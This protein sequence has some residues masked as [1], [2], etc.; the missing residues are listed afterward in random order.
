MLTSLAH[1]YQNAQAGPP[2]ESWGLINGI[3]KFFG[4]EPFDPKGATAYDAAMKT[5]VNLAINRTSDFATGA[6]A[7]GLEASMMATP[8]P[9]KDPDALYDIITKSIGYGD[10]AYDRSQQLI[11]T[12][13]KNAL[14]FI[15]DFAE[16][17]DPQTYINKAKEQI[18]P[19]KGSTSEGA[20]VTGGR[21]PESPTPIDENTVGVP[22]GAN[23]MTINKI[24]KST[25]RNQRV[26]LGDG[27]FVWG[28]GE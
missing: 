14:G 28:R 22:K 3:M 9:K 15:S 12:Q 16:K 20:S 19:F 2:A 18:G 26:D 23:A 21:G 7:A 24:I 5:A 4:Q 27:T 6:P 8:D 1:I 11:K 17:N 13:P 10:L 25:P